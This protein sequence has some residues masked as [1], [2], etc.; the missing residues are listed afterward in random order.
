MQ[1]EPVSQFA[2]FFQVDSVLSIALDHQISQKASWSR[3]LAQYHFL[4]VQIP[5]L[6]NYYDTNFKPIHRRLEMASPGNVYTA[7]SSRRSETGWDYPAPTRYEQLYVASMN[8][9]LQYITCI[10]F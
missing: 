7:R 4:T 10:C 9:L 6:K 8:S 5:N 1:R 3:I 2:V